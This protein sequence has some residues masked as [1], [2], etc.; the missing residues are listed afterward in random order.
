ME[1]PFGAYVV[2]GSG[3]LKSHTKEASVRFYTRQHEFY[4]GIDLHARW[5]YV[6]I[7]PRMARSSTTRTCLLV[8]KRFDSKSCRGARL[9]RKH[10]Y[11]VEKDALSGLNRWERES[12]PALSQPP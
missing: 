10:R 2:V 7:S 4:C 11:P 1:A 5:M 9:S 3:V 6:C 8:P 12:A